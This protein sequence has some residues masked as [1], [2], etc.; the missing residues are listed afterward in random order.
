MDVLLM[1]H[2]QDNDCPHAII[3]IFA[4]SCT[5]TII[6]KIFITLNEGNKTP[7]IIS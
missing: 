6:S 3:I 2:F 5:L 7:Q 4:L 1:V